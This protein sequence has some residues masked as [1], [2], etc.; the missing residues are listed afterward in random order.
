MKDSLYDLANGRNDN[1]QNLGFDYKDQILKRT[2]SP[3]LFMDPVRSGM[4]QQFENWLYFLV[5][6]VKLLK[7]YYNFTVTKNYRKIN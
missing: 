6:S 3:Y 4:L 2:V 7:T 5:E 1:V